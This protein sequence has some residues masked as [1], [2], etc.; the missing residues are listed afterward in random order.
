MLRILGHMDRRLTTLL[1]TVF[2]YG[3]ATLWDTSNRDTQF[4]VPVVLEN[5]EKG[6][7]VQVYVNGDT[8]I[9]LKQEDHFFIRKDGSENEA[10]W[11][12]IA[13]DSGCTLVQE[14][15]NYSMRINGVLFQTRNMTYKVTNEKI[16]FVREVSSDI[17]HSDQNVHS[18]HFIKRV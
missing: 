17:Y 11:G 14:N 10:A 3:G 18:I 15:G 1:G 4:E 13:S 2:N 8:V 16:C 9:G 7:L 6:L 5:G 12:G